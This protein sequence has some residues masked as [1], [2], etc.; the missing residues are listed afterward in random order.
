MTRPVAVILGAGMGGSGVARSLAPTHDVVIVDRGGGKAMALAEAVGGVAATAD[1]LD[2][3]SV[4]GLQEHLVDRFG[5]VDAVI[6]LVGGWQGSPSVDL[7]ALKAWDAIAPGV[8]GTLRVTSVAFRDA[9]LAS[10]GTYVMVSSTTAH[11]P[12]AGNV[13]YAT[14]KAAAESWLGGLA[15]S[16]A[17]TSARAVIVAVKALVTADMRAAEPNRN[18]PGYTDIDALGEA[19]KGILEGEAIANGARVDLTKE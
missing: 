4:T 11:R 19:I 14:A 7:D 18:F 8:F 6:H 1:L 13:A 3:D 16:F 2:I 5:R 17:E 15:D 12:S 10:G 9:L